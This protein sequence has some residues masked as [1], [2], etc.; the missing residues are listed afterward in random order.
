MNQQ[1]LFYTEYYSTLI[2]EHAG[3]SDKNWSM[4]NRIINTKYCE[5]NSS[6]IPF[7]VD[8]TVDINGWKT[9][10]FEMKICYPGL[11]AGLGYAHEAGALFPDKTQEIKLG[12]S[13]DYVSGLPYIP[14][15][16]LKGVLRSAFSK[17]DAD[18]GKLLECDINVIHEIEEEIFEKGQ[19]IFLDVFPVSGDKN[20]QL[21]GMEYI[22]SHKASEPA[23][24]GLTAVNPLKLLK[25]RPGVKILFRFLLKDTMVYIGNECFE[26][27][28]AEK[29]ELYAVILERYG[30]GAKTNTGYGHIVRCDQGGSRKM[31]YLWL[32]QDEG[33]TK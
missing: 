11:V 24:D 17:Y 21:L 10:C 4:N 29:K 16:S 28:A 20:R 1:Y 19:D 23:Y 22:T 6:S 2:K 14:G 7:S 31:P 32:T 8:N 33:R 25:I 12:F 3:T 13:F 9:H 30:F 18:I 26:L 15:S 5:D 27:T